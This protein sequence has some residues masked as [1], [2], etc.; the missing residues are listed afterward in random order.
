MSALS[1][2]TYY[3]NNKRK[4]GPVTGIIALAVLAI[5][6]SGALTGSLFED[7][8]RELAY[9]D[10]FA[11]VFSI[12]RSGLSDG[13]LRQ[14]NDH[15][16]VAET[17]EV[18]RATTRTQGIFGSEGRP[19]YFLS[20]A[21]RAAFPDRLGWRLAEG[22]WPRT[23]T[24]EVA[25]TENILRNRGLEVGGRIG[26]VAD[27]KDWLSGEWVIVG[28]L[29]S[30]SVTG[31]VGDRAYFRERFQTDPDLPPE[32]ANRP[33]V[34]TIKPVEGKELELEAVLDHLPK[35]QVFA[36]HRTKARKQLDEQLANV[37]L[38]IWILNGISIVVVA[39]ALGL[40]N[41]IFFMQRANEFG[42]LAALGY[43]KWYLSLRTF[44][45]AVVTVAAGWALGILLSQGI[46]T[47]L[48][49]ALF[50]P[51][52]LAPLTIMTSRV[53]LFTIPVPVTVVVFS[54]A[55]VLW[56]LWR[57]DPVAI[58]ERRD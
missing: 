55:V 35:D 4:V 53:F 16:A 9:Y 17:Y 14:L 46:Y 5:S 7:E 58:I 22:R 51:R 50:D 21:D 49:A 37:N 15:P 43:T 45:E 52:G 8:K 48:N 27:E 6:V 26:E 54:V 41:V 47:V 2:F 29:A 42:L 56:Q 25:L 36:V 20:E 40:L 32:V 44:L 34:L 24:N 3:L 10:R 39:L 1:I 57:M 13:L 30:D 33:H 18:E 11:V 38:I 28:A 12:Q 23:G 19:I 31:G